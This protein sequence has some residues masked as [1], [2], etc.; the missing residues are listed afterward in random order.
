MKNYKIIVYVLD[1]NCPPCEL[2]KTYVSEVCTLKG[3]EHEIVQVTGYSEHP[4]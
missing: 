3:R 2:M 4:H 1:R